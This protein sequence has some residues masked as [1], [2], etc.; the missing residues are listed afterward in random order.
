MKVKCTIIKLRRGA[1]KCREKSGW[2]GVLVRLVYRAVNLTRILK[3]CM[4]A[5]QVDWWIRKDRIDRIFQMEGI[6]W[7]EMQRYRITWWAC[8]SSVKMGK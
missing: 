6:V 5:H 4:G 8:C 1:Q 3:N 2:P 7:A